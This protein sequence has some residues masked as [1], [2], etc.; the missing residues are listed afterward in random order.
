MADCGW[1]EKHLASQII[2]ANICY[3]NILGKLIFKTN[4]VKIAPN[5]I[6]AYLIHKTSFIGK[7]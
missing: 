5:R 6:S 7:G 2:T 1:N 4:R 3:I